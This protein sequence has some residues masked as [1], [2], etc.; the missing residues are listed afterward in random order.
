[1]RGRPGGRNTSTSRLPITV[2]TTGEAMHLISDESDGILICEQC[3]KVRLDNEY[4]YARVREL[5]REVAKVRQENETLNRLLGKE[6]EQ[7]IKQL[8]YSP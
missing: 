7:G 8:I 5:E 4:L 2:H 1:M 6:L 3:A